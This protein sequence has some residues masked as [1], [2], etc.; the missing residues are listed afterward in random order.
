M[1]EYIQAGKFKARCLK[2][3]DKVQKT[4][5]KIIITKRNKPIAQLVPIEQDEGSLFGKMKGTI[6]VVGDIMS[7]V[8]EVWDADR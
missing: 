3:M 5:R 8:D 1:S 6:H 2:L 7:P 4:K